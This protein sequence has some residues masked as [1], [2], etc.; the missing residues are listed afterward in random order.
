[1][2]C[3][4]RGKGFLKRFLFYGGRYG[5]TVQLNKLLVL[6]LFVHSDNTRDQKGKKSTKRCLMKNSPSASKRLKTD[7]GD[8]DY[9]DDVYEKFMQGTTRADSKNEKA[10]WHEVHI[11][12]RKKLEK[13]GSLDR[14]EVVHLSLWTDLIVNGTI[15]GVDEE[16]DWSRYRHITSIDP[17]PKRVLEFPLL[18]CQHLLH[19]IR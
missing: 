15:K 13:M 1:M 8:D 6:S 12:L 19:R 4:L 10:K 14:F 11:E 7:I 17:L 5:Y 16:P 2:K 9:D 3:N 18:E